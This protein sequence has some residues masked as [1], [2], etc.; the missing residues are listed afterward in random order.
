WE[1]QG[2]GAPIILDESMARK[3]FGGAPALGRAILQQG[4]AARGVT[5]RSRTNIGIVGSVVGSDVREGIQPFAY[6]PFAGSRISTV[7][8]RLAGPVG[9]VGELVRQAVRDAAPDVPV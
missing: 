4:R 8:V 1:R 7:L 9:S 6:E 5:W 3:L 2:D